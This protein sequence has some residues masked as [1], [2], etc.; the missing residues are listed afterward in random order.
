M[1]PNALQPW[2][3]EGELW[4]QVWWGWGLVFSGHGSWGTGTLLQG[5]ILLPRPRVIVH[6]KQ[7][8]YDVYNIEV[9]E[10]HDHHEVSS[11]AHTAFLDVDSL[12]AAWVSWW[13]GERKWLPLEPMQTVLILTHLLNHSSSVHCPHLTSHFSRS[14]EVYSQQKSPGLTAAHTH[15]NHERYYALKHAY[16]EIQMQILAMRL[17]KKVHLV[18]R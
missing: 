16:M 5:Y 10:G 2:Q 17:Q 13:R 18:C 9:E 7:Q 12:P 3:M 8:S 15:H 1:Y 11:G 4:A 6:I 14:A